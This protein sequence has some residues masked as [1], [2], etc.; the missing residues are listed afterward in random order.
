MSVRFNYESLLSK[1]RQLP[2]VKDAIGGVAGQPQLVKNGKAISFGG[3]P[4]LGFSVDPSR[5]QFSSLTISKGDW[6]ND[7]EVVVDTSTADKKNIKVGDTIGVQASGAEVKMR[8]SG[9]VKFGSAASL[10]GATLAGF[11]LPTA[12]KLFNKVGKLDDIRPAAPTGISP[13]QL[14]SPIRPGPPSRTP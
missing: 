12:Q 6:P 14:V 8:V 11:T 1:V 9:L 3:A 7:N 5:P 13:P 10:G 2:D 4:N